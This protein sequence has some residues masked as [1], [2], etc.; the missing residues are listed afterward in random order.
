MA[1]PIWKGHITFGLVN[2]PVTLYSVETRNDLHFRLIDSR[3]HARIRYERVNEETGEEV[4]WDK[5]V[6]GYEYDGG[7]YVLLSDEE[8][9]RASVELTRTVEIEEFVD[10]DAI[11]LIYFDKPYVLV[12]AKGGEKGYALLR[13][14]LERS[15]KVGIAKVVMRSRQHLAALIPEG[16][17]LVLNLMRF[18]QELRDLGE[19][20]VPGR[21]L[22]RLKVSDREIDMALKLVEGMSGEWE[23][24]KHQDEYREALMQMI[25]RKIESGRTEEIAA[26]EE[27]EEPP[28][29]VN[30]ME[31]LRKSVEQSTRRKD[32]KPKAR[33]RKRSSRTRA[34]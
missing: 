33:G 1:R 12:P 21:D 34:G 32:G 13:E 24:R 2:I 29:T 4:P 18:Q 17:H 28:A 26:S 16:D 22:K 31:M 15:G 7:S 10:R 19:F 14:A 9:E 3:N 23:P 6:K 25:Q 11:D 8:L 27:A 5:I 20:D 30:L